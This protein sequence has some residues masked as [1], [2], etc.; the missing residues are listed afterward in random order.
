M[1]YESDI[2]AGRE[3]VLAVLREHIECHA[4]SLRMAAKGLG[5]SAPFLSDVLRG[6]TEPGPRILKKLGF[7]RVTV[8]FRDPPSQ[9][10][11][12]KNG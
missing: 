3:S 10:H 1:K 9:P 4:P 11:A 8:F 12:V 2:I 7:R 5:V 6:R